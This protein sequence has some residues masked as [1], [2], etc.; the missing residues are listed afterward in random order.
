M[1]VINR[2]QLTLVVKE[3][4]LEWLHSCG[5]EFQDVSEDELR[6]DCNAYLIEEVESEQALLSILEREHERMLEAELADWVEDD[7]LW[8][9]E[10]NFELFERF[11]DCHV[12]TVVYDLVDEEIHKEDL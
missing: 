6:E 5:E 1:K 11:F 12:Q 4:F 9:E 8:P 10:R 2:T 7:A 3:S